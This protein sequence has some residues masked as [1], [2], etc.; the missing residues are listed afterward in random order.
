MKIIPTLG[1]VTIRATQIPTTVKFLVFQVHSFVYNATLSYNETILPN[2]HVNGTNIGLVKE[3]IGTAAQVFY[4]NFNLNK[5]ITV[6]I[7]V[8]AYDRGGK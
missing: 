6:L 5:D 4:K 7:A 1:S 8:Q 3:P 2:Y